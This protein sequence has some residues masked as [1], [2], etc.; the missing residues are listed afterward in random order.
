MRYRVQHTTLY[1]YDRVVYLERHELR[2]R[3][4]SDGSQHVL[5]YVCRVDPE[6]W[7]RSESIDAEGNPV[8][9]VWFRSPAREL[10]VA[11]S[12]EVETLRTNPFDYLLAGERSHRLPMEYGEDLRFA[13]S[14]YRLPDVEATVARFA[15]IAAAEAGYDTLDFLAVLSQRIWATCRVVRREDGPPQLPATTL[16]QGRGACR[17]LTVLFM[18]ACRALGLAARFV[19]G[20]HPGDAGPDSDLHAWAEVYLPG[21]GWRGYDPTLGL[22]VADQHIALAA[23]AD[24]ARTLPVSGTFRGTD[25]RA[26]MRADIGVSSPSLQ[27][28]TSA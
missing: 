20:Y 17:D 15:D 7:L 1:Q 4:R 18:S 9:L 3:P 6:P 10:R 25:A 12:L 19:S 13:L 22:A 5:S 28:Q 8:T 23:S 2:L 16:R 27:S 11:T 24:P 26:A 14:H 21:G